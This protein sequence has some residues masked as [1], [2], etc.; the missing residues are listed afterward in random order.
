MARNGLSVLHG[1]RDK[2]AIT[3][4]GLQE[5][6]FKI[7]KELRRVKL[8]YEHLYQIV[9]VLSQSYS[10]CMNNCW[11]ALIRYIKLNSMINECL[12]RYN[13]KEKTI[14]DSLENTGFMEKAAEISNIMSDYGKLHKAD[15]RT[16]ISEKEE[17]IKR[18]QTQTCQLRTAIEN[19][20]RDFNTSRNHCIIRRYGKLKEMIRK[21]ITEM[22]NCHNPIY[23]P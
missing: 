7:T 4:T 16:D 9:Y 3:K 15:L 11:P 17:E 12:R 5:D 20:Q 8:D 18:I 14:Y 21:T 23:E 10:C 13:A 6:D 1:I 19:L 22:Q 2:I